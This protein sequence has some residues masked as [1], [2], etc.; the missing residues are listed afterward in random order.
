[1]KHFIT[2]AVLLFL[3]SASSATVH[4]VTCQNSPSH[5][6]PLTVNAAVGDTIHWTW[7]VGNHPV[8]P[9]D[10]S[11][12]PAGAPMFYGVVD[13]T[14]HDYKTVLTVPG[15]YYYDCHPNSPHGE[16][17]TIIVGGALAATPNHHHATAE[18]ISAYPNPSSGSLTFGI[19]CELMSEQNIISVFD[20]K[21][22]M[23]TE[24]TMS[25]MRSVIDLS[26]QPKG[27]YLLRFN[28]GE[29]VLTKEIVIE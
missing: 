6:L 5:F 29:A 23:I 8:G 15:S 9:Q 1:M 16:E 17:G 25:G 26:N 4:T 7:V 20:L 2:S 27:I 28:N 12:I 11:Y 18:Q 19:D 24:T 10:P 14:H 3:A 22:K 13:A 21:G